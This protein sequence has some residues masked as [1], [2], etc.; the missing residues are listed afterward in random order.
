MSSRATRGLWFTGGWLAVAVGSIGVV[1]PGLPSTGFFI[2]AAACFSRSSPRFERWVL[3]LPGV[4]PMVRDYRAGLD[5]PRAAKVAAMSSIALVCSASAFLA[6]DN[7]WVRALVLGLGAVGIYWIL[8]RVPTRAADPPIVVATAGRWFGL[9]AAAEAV[10][11]LGL[12]IGMLVKYV[13]SGSERGAEL[14][15]MIH[16][17]V[18]LVYVAVALV[19]ARALRWPSRTLLLALF[20]SVPPGGSLVFEHW[21]WRTGQLSVPRPRV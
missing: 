12:F 8:G 17:V 13:G 10:S 15:G 18:V 11:W 19:A 1:V 9:A 6:L 3:D 16:G 21:A 4:G 7:V 5:M 20:A 2:I 14:F